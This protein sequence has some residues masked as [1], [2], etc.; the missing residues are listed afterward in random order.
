MAY[1]GLETKRVSKSL[2]F[3]STE[4]EIGKEYRPHIYL[5]REMEETKS[6]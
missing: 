6:L 5:W 2:R 4:K 1:V 3:K